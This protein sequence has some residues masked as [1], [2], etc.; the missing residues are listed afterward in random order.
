L[1]STSHPLPRGSRNP[2]SLLSNKCELSVTF[3]SFAQGEWRKRRATK[4]WKKVSFGKIKKLPDA[5]YD[6]P[7]DLKPGARYDLPTGLSIKNAVV[8]PNL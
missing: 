1:L 4:Q 8:F 3:L 7:Y 2:Q 6:Y 5:G